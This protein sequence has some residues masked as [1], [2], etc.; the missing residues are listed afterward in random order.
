MDLSIP[1][2]FVFTTNPATSPQNSEENPQRPHKVRSYPPRFKVLLGISSTSL[3]SLD[4][5]HDS[6]LSRTNKMITCIITTTIIKNKKTHPKKAQECTL[7]PTIQHKMKVPSAGTEKTTFKK[8][9][10]YLNKV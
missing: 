9:S 4:H 10:T 1:K 3:L 6:Q 5:H 7:T 8:E 2:S